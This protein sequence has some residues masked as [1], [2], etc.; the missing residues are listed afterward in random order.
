MV[1]ANRGR[2]A[3]TTDT[4]ET[5]EPHGIGAPIGAEPPIVI[6]AN[7]LPIE[8]YRHRGAMT[9]RSSPGG[10]VSAIAP[11]LA[12]RNGTWV[13]WA[14]RSRT[15][16][17]DEVDGAKI[18]PVRI[19]YHEYERY[20]DG[21][22]NG[23]L[24]PLYHDAIEPAQFHRE[25][26]A[27]YSAVNSRF[28]SA[29]ATAAP[30]NSTVWVH[31]YQLQLV[32]Q[33]LRAL[34]PDVRI[35]FFLHIPFPPIELFMRLPWRRQVI[36]GLLGADLVGFQLPQGA[37]NFLQLC[38]R[39][40][41]DH[42]SAGR[43]F[44]EDRVVHVKAF[45]ISIDA[46]AIEESAARPSTGRDVRSLRVS[47]GE[48]EVLFLGVDRLD[49]TKGIDIR[50]RAFSEVLDEGLLG[51][52]RVA[53]IQVAN[54]TR[55][56][57]AHYAELRQRVEQLVGS[58]NG[59]H[60]QLGRAVV[61]YLHRN[62]TPDELV[63]LYRAADVMLVTPLR[64]GMNLVAKEYVAA[65]SDLGGVLVLSEFAG[66]AAELRYALRVNPYDIESV[67][68]AIVKSVTM[69]RSDRRQRMRRMRSVVFRRDV[70]RWANEFLH[71]LE[72]A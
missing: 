24:W 41:D 4:I 13:G 66:A 31:D 39:L 3:K 23:M 28:A 2:L 44:H 58:I 57:A 36:E 55:E 20:Y 71:T 30:A 14:G 29:V 15:T 63:A 70:Y 9:W 42:V 17:P 61:Q 7:R 52:R 21:C 50:L 62:V 5:A 35:G 48:P 32:P 26:W 34:R 19:P 1:A 49:Y 43:V 68:D 33:M 72:A 8:S 46:K 18:V 51:S 10:L 67:K 54:P 60:G 65:R 12:R 27:S 56:H 11:V 64:D 22:S 47:L 38:R 59:E 37:E 25:W 16:P 53:L 6:V 45:P 69:D 40:L